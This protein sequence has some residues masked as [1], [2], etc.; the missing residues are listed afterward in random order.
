MHKRIIAA[1]LVAP[2][3]ALAPA[4]A[5]AHHCSKSYRHHHAR[6]ADTSSYGSSKSM[7]S[8]R[9]GS[10][11]QNMNQGTGSNPPSSTDQGTTS[12]G[13]SGGGI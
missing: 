3:I 6:N 10:Q 1:A 9:T 4:S 8:G 5:W 12:S 2:I 11:N 7:K 13:K